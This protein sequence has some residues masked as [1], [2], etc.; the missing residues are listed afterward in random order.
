M[1]DDIELVQFMT[2]EIG[3]DLIVSFFVDRR[4]DPT[5]GRSIILFRDKKWEHLVAEWERGVKV[6]DED[7]P[8][9]KAADNNYLEGIRIKG[10]EEGLQED[11]LRQAIQAD[12]RL[13]KRWNRPIIVCFF[14]YCLVSTWPRQ[15]LPIGAAQ[16]HRSSSEPSR[17]G[18][19]RVPGRRGGGAIS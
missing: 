9:D 5:C 18:I 11:E 7:F 13:T 1:T 4:H 8:E 3:D 15:S 10:S 14:S 19:C 16:R 17:T 2:A 12:N 6:S